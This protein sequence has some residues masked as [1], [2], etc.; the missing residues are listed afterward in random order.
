[1]EMRRDVVLYFLKFLHCFFLNQCHSSSVQALKFHSKLSLHK[2]WFQNV[3]FFCIFLCNKVIFIYIFMRSVF[4]F[5][6]VLIISYF[7]MQGFKYFPYFDTFQKI[8][9][10]CGSVSVCVSNI[11]TCF[12]LSFLYGPICHITCEFICS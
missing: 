2:T 6:Q 4:C 10:V 1:M 3:S 9:L 5:A 11:C 7:F 8:L 12:F